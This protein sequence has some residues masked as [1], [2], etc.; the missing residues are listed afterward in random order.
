MKLNLNSSRLIVGVSVCVLAALLFTSCGKLGKKGQKEF[1]Q[2]QAALVAQDYKTAVTQFALAANQGH[3]EAQYQIGLCYAQGKGV[4]ESEYE[5]FKWYLKAAN[6]GHAEAQYQV[7]RCYEEGEGM[8]A[9][10]AEAFKWYEKAA[11]KG[12]VYAMNALAICYKFGDGVRQDDDEAYKWYKKA[13]EKGHV[14]VRCDYVFGD[15]VSKEK[16]SVTAGFPE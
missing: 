1:E 13:V 16:V 10:K 2:G 9:D 4:E 5:A 3:A 14:S 15:E 8:K 6:Q 11:E 12:N 7:G